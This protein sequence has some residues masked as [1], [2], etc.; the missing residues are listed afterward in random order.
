MACSAGEPEPGKPS[1]PRGLPGCGMPRTARPAGG[2]TEPGVVASRVG[3]PGPGI[4][5]APTRPYAGHVR[6]SREETT[7][8]L[9]GILWHAL[10]RLQHA[11]P[12]PVGRISPLARPAAYGSDAAAVSQGTGVLHRIARLWAVNTICA[13]SVLLLDSLYR[14]ESLAPVSAV[15]VQV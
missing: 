12:E 15:D 1:C 6:R 10:F 4:I 5:C 3:W 11:H 13:Q 14:Q 7:Q 9:P 2:G 8:D